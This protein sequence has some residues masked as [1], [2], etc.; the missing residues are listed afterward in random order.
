[1]PALGL[2]DEFNLTA[3][4]GVVAGAK[5]AALL[6][7]SQVRDCLIVAALQT[8]F[9][10]SAYARVAARQVVCKGVHAAPTQSSASTLVLKL[11]PHN[12]S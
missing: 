9:N 11:V 6:T 1:M 3:A 7:R 2:T 8:A 12:A 10:G 5:A 4:R